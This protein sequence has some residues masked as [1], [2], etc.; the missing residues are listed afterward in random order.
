[1]RLLNT[2]GMLTFIV[3]WSANS[4]IVQSCPS[5]I[6]DAERV[7]CAGDVSPATEGICRARGCVW[8]LTTT[9]NTPF[10]FHDNTSYIG[11][12]GKSIHFEY[13]NESKLIYHS[14]KFVI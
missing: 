8:C 13:L 3:V 7:D 1:M 2:L 9:A 4:V 14:S 6:P 11:F 10:C 12:K 5:T